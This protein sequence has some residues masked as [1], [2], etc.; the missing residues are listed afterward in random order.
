MAGA[1]APWSA[2]ECS[3]GRGSAALFKLIP[4]SPYEPVLFNCHGEVVKEGNWEKWEA[5]WIFE[6][7]TESERTLK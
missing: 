7:Q 6:N 3:V 5:R 2:S 4:W 1:G